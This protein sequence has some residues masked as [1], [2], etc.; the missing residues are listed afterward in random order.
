MENITL[1]GMPSAGKS[2]IGERLARRLGYRFIDV[3]QVIQKQEGKLL[4]EIIREQGLQ[5]FAQ[6]ENRINSQLE[7]HMSVIAP[8]GSVVYGKEA[9]EHLREI[10][11]IVYLKVPY[12]EVESRLGDLTA[13]GV[14]IREGMTLR[15]LYEERVPLYEKYGDVILDETG[16]SIEECV[17]QLLVLLE[18][19]D[20]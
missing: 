14:T 16:L 1:I 7:A 11:R 5:G 20:M 18:K 3:D 19:K 10:S 13:R 8:G 4:R 2:V 15:D 6:V 9:M 17:E 12:E